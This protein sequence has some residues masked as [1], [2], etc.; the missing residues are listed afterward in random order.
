MGKYKFS[1]KATQDLLGIWDYSN[2]NWGKA[3]AD[4]YYKELIDACRMVAEV[5]QL[6]HHFKGVSAKYLG[7]WKGRHA[8]FYTILSPDSVEIVRIMHYRMDFKSRLG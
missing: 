3:Q 6:G 7:Y 1:R 8:I 5:P 4:K 2:E